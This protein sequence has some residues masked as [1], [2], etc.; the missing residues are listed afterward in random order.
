[1][2]KILNF[3]INYIYE[4]INKIYISYMFKHCRKL[5]TDKASAYNMLYGE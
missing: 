2:T 5:F 1:M 4:N 3:M